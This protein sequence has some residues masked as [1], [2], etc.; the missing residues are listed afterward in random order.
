MGVKMTV[1]FWVQAERFYEFWLMNIFSL[2][3]ITLIVMIFTFTYTAK[4][5]RK[6]P[7]TILIS[8]MT[9]L[10][11]IGGMGHFK[12]GVYLPEAMA[13]NPLIRDRMP[14]YFGYNTVGSVEQ[15][16]YADL[17]DLVSL[18]EMV[19]YDELIVEEP[20]TYFGSGDYSHYFQRENGDYFRHS[21]RISFHKELEEPQLIGS[22]FVLKDDSFTEIGFKNPVNTMFVGIMLPADEEGK[23]YKP[24]N[25]M[26]FLR[27]EK[28]VSDW[29][30]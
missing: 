21:T 7:F 15:S 29:N 12:Y 1:E 25:E 10:V 8:F 2:I 27:V 16:Y 11:F 20:L 14:T 4:G 5:Q 24:E 28:V 9:I 3:V 19:L 13:V 26:D 30:F 6:K 17:N 23:H 18:R 22:R